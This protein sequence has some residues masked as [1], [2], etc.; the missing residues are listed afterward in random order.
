MANDELYF[1]GPAEME[2][3]VFITCLV[4][5]CTPKLVA[6]Q[7]EV[8]SNNFIKGTERYTDHKFSNVD[9]DQDLTQADG[10][11]SDAPSVDAVGGSSA[12]G[13]AVPD[14]GVPA[15]VNPGDDGPLTDAGG[16]GGDGEGND[17][18]PKTTVGSPPVEGVA[19][20]SKVEGEGRKEG[21]S[22]V[23][24]DNNAPYEGW[25]NG[26]TVEDDSFMLL[27]KI[28]KMLEE[29]GSG[30]EQDNTTP[31]DGVVVASTVEKDSSA[32][33]EGTVGGS[34][35]QDLNSVSEGGVADGRRFE[36]DDRAPTEKTAGGS[37]VDDNDSALYEGH[38]GI[39]DVKDDSSAPSEGT[40]EGDGHEEDS[41][42]SYEGAADGGSAKD[43]SSALSEGTT[44]GASN[45]PLSPPP[46]PLPPQYPYALP[47]GREMSV[48]KNVWRDHVVMD[49]FPHVVVHDVLDE[50]L[51]NELELTFPADVDVIRSS[52]P[53][54][55]PSRAPP[56][57]RFNMRG[58][59]T[60]N[61]T[62]W[63]HKLLPP[64]WQR[65]IQYH[66]SPQFFQELVDIFEPALNHSRP[67]MLR[68][69]KQESFDK[70]SSA[71]RGTA[72]SLKADVALDCQV[73]INSNTKRPT[74]KHR[75]IGPHHDD[76]DEIFAGLLYFKGEEDRTKGGDL[77]LYSCKG[78]CREISRK[79]RAGL[80]AKLKTEV[81]MYHPATLRLA[82]T[83]PY[84]KNVLVLFINTDKA[85]NGLHAVHSVSPRRRAQLS[86]RLVNILGE[87]VDPNSAISSKFVRT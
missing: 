72:A 34:G 58:V 49:P 48:L 17:R 19:Y 80:K 33:H 29:I 41:S 2:R 54:M 3:W 84:A 61:S 28:E 63:E 15:Y 35:V 9:F 67:E 38:V 46:V 6:Q 7:Y 78:P 76:F 45:G 22:S 85:P 79:G 8:L 68:E 23:E 1:C 86:R 10:V 47:S 52:N 60:T 73:A 44:P 81:V 83:V 14:Q 64:V 42:T 71:V 62:S 77:E 24:Q 75:V 31:H 56:N 57:K 59:F 27:E 53:E 21:S 16:E 20:F 25:K 4:Y 32:P 30:L 12:E 36:G 5:A 55:K 13:N 18:A 65:F 69:M 82:K 70:L 50:T 39:S 40:A 11:T 37:V 66:T 87:V 43:D 51:Y 26:S 74:N